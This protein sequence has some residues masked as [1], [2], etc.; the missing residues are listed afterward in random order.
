MIYTITVEFQEQK[1]T[2][3]SIHKEFYWLEKK[4]TNEIG[5]IGLDELNVWWG[6]RENIN[7]VTEE[8]VRRIQEDQKK[9]QQTSQQIKKDKAINNKFAKFL[10]FLIEDIK[11]DELIKQIYRTFFTTIHE[12]T[13]M[14]HIRKSMNT[15]VVVGIFMPFYQEQIKEIKLEDIY[16]DIR[17][18]DGDVHLTKYIEYIKQLLPKYHDNIMIDKQEFIKLLK[19]ISEQYQLTEKLT[20]EKAIEFENTLKTELKIKE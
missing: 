7:K 12:E 9:A 18:F 1:H 5:W 16:Q 6:V 17:Y 19:N 2:F 15:V 14:T 11:N 20:T 13:E 4:M 10:S 3:S 8:A